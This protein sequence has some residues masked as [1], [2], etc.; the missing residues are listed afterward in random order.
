M[1]DQ[2]EGKSALDWYFASLTQDRIDGNIKGSF[3]NDADPTGGH[4]G[5][6]NVKK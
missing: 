1:S 5:H 3:V 6:G 2:L 4:G